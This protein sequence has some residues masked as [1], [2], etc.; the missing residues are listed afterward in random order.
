M[1]ADTLAEVLG[2][3]A[4]SD[5]PRRD[6]HVEQPVCFEPLERLNEAG[7][8]L[9]GSGHGNSLLGGEALGLT[10]PAEANGRRG[11]RQRQYDSPS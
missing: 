3:A 8:V 9:A 1:V 2:A 11:R 6:A 5:V 4:G 10:R 7:G